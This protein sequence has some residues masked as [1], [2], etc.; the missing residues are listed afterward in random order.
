MTPA[1]QVDPAFAVLIGRL[2]DLAEAGR[3]LGPAP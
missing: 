1:M 2:Y 3:L